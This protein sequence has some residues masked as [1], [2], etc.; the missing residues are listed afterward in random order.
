MNLGALPEILLSWLKNQ[1][2]S[3]PPPEKV[4]KALAELMPGQQYDGKV[5]QTLANGRSLVQIAGN[6]LDM[7]LPAKSQPGDSVRLTYLTASSRPTFVLQP[8]AAPTAQ[9]GPVRLSDAA[10]QV[11]AL[12]RFA[13]AAPVAQGA[14]P[15]AQLSPAGTLQTSAGATLATATPAGTASAPVL[16]SA[17]VLANAATATLTAGAT[18]LTAT[19]TATAAQAQTAANAGNSAAQAGAALGTARPLIANAAVFFGNGGLSAAMPL[20]TSAAGTVVPGVAGMGMPVDGVRNTAA[21]QAS[22]LSQ[23]VVAQA[24]EPA[25]A[26]LSQMLRR[27]LSQS[28]MFYESHL[29]KWVNGQLSLQQVQQEPQ[30]RLLE[31][32]TR[33]LNLPRLEG[34]PEEAARL[35]GRQLMMLEGGPLLWQGMVWPGQY[36]DWLVEERENAF[37]G[38]EEASRWRTELRLTL[39]RLGEVTAELGIS[40]RGLKIDLASVSAET[41]AEI[42]TALPDLIQRMKDAN[43]N[44]FSLKA[45]LAEVEDPSSTKSEGNTDTSPAGANDSGGRA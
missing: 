29:G 15:A 12:V 38:E 8:D 43:I 25:T 44:L 18:S 28:G 9:T 2:A 23:G 30:A 45:G 34:M 16:S 40:A 3:T 11:G 31:T 10:Q 14:T 19:S 32:A 24:S 5:L 22:L 6:V 4:A 17:A 42:K 33:H 37:Q 26:A 13:Q 36:M 7:A 21:T 1:G 41:L 20:T 35:A 39:P 27:T